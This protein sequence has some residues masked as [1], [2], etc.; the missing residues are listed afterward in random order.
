[1]SD[2]G[3]VGN[4]DSVIRDIEAQATV[5]AVASNKEHGFSVRSGDGINT[6]LP[7]KPYFPLQRV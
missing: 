4:M 2:L 7:E 5:L 6:M 1:L 3:Y